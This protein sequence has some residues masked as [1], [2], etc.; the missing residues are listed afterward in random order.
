MKESKMELPQLNE[1]HQPLLQQHDVMPSL[2]S[3]KTILDA[4][5]GSRM[6]WFDKSNKNVLF[7]D[8]R[9]DVFKSSNG[10]ETEVK[11]DIVAD[12]RNMP[13]ADNTFYHVVF[14]PPHRND[15][16]DDHWMTHQYGQ[17]FPTWETDIRKG[18]DECMRVLKP[19]GTLIFKWH[20]KNILVKK[21]LALLP[22]EPLYGHKSGK[23]SN[24]HWLAFVKGF[25]ETQGSCNEA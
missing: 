17:L 4:C 19:G 16:A 10:T 1:A 11:P 22:I 12:F 25:S 13:F 15:N 20:E 21:I 24:T 2:L 14:D 5:C 3:G 9:S 8:I 23:R 18:F 6:F 7:A